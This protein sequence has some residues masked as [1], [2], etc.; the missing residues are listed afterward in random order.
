MAQ[1]IIYP[2][3]IA[4]GL[5]ALPIGLVAMQVGLR[6]LMGSEHDCPRAVA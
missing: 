1:F 3:G 4:Y 6:H 2:L 5:Q